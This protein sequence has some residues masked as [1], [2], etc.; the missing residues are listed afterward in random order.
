MDEAVLHLMFHKDELEKLVNEARTKGVNLS[1]TRAL[2][3]PPPSDDMSMPKL[4]N[5]FTPRQPQTIEQTGLNRTFLYEHLTRI[6]YNK[7]RVTGLE[8]VEEMGLPYQIIECLEL[9]DQN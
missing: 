4:L 9:R 3:D 7:G 1:A 2:G 5:G 6:I 8:L